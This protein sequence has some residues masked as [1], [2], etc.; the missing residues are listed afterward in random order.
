MSKYLF[1]E[2]RDPFDSKDVLQTYG[3]VKELC[4]QG[5]DVALYL[6]QNGVLAVR[7]DAK[8][9][10]LPEILSDKKA[11]VLV[12]DYS[13]S[14]RGI[15]KDQVP[16]SAKVSNADELVDLIMEDQRKPIWH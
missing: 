14:E 5:H 2:S 3:L 4:N 7:K 6:I 8:V 13:L 10:L 9:T 15:L 16:G 1:I 11:R 12:D